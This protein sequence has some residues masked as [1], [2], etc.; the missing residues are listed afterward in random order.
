MQTISHG[1][2][3]ECLMSVIVGQ[4]NQIQAL[5]ELCWWLSIALKFEL[6]SFI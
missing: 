2:L 1:D 4:H 5:N 6:S 3:H